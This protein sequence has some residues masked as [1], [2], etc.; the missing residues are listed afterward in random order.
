M[1][2]PDLCDLP[3]GKICEQLGQW[4]LDDTKKDETK[5]I[6]EQAKHF[7][8]SLEEFNL[9]EYIR[10]IHFDTLKVPSIPFQLP[11]THFYHG[12][13]EMKK[14][15]LDFFKSTVLHPAITNIYMFSDMDMADMA[16]DKEFAKKWMLGLALALK[17][18]HHI[19][20]IHNIHRPMDEL[21][22]GL[23]GWIPLYMTGQ[24][25]PFYFPQDNSDI[26]CHLEYYS[27]TTCCHGE[28][29]KGHHENGMY[30]VSKAQ[31]DLAYH[32]RRTKELFEKAKPL[33]DIYNEQ[34]EIDFY[35][36]FKSIYRNNGIWHNKFYHLPFYT[37]ND[38]LVE[39]ICDYNHFNKDQI[40]YFK[41]EVWERKEYFLDN[42]TKQAVYDEF[43]VLTKEEFDCHPT[44]LS[45]TNITANY[46]YELYLEHQSLT[47]KAGS[48]HSH[49]H[50]TFS[51]ETLFRNIKINVLHNK[52]ALITKD[53]HPHIHFVIHN[54]KLVNAIELAYPIMY[55]E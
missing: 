13:E 41:N 24:V 15:E 11:T 33:M 31:K 51:E 39:K 48:E 47:K 32:K 4:L 3:F 21:M 23:E 14:A 38:E 37:L 20:T 40:T 46:N 49:Y 42:I 5:E 12:I 35:T 6:A 16:T 8:N 45:C 25:H 19:Y 28:S 22:L 18:G 54:P 7:L 10:A 53:N 30:Y 44:F 9:D 52:V 50:P 29:I 55:E 17:K 43:P 1:E 2:N 34:Q 27:E 26:F 36:Y